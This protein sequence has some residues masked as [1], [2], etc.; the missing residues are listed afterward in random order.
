MDYSNL[1]VPKHVGIIMD[2]NGRWASERGLSRSEGHKAGFKRIK[3]LSEYILNHGIQ[4]LSIFAFSTENFKRSK[5]EV[6]YLMQLFT[7]AFKHEFEYYK[8]KNI[9][10]IFSG[11]REPLPKKVWD[12]MQEI[13]KLTENNTGG[14]LNICLNYG[15]QAEIVDACKK[16]H[17]DVLHNKM[18]ISKLDENTFQHY[19]YHDLEPIDFLIRT[20]GEERISNFMLWQ[21]SYAE[22]YFTKTYFPDFDESAFDAS[23][24]EYTKR[25]RKFGGVENDQKSN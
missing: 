1:E 20:S 16:I 14:I 3:S 2:G 13:V 19:L 17:E 6:D 23:I 22:L 15:G 21:L 5:T 8:N 7:H 12:T 11:R 10:V 9:R 4:I 25:N 18:D 24:L